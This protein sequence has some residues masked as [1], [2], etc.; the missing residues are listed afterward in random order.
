MKKQILLC[1]LVGFLGIFL[2]IFILGLIQFLLL[3]ILGVSIEKNILT[4]L[5]LMLVVGGM[6]I[7]FCIMN[8]NKYFKSN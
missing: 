5:S 7:A 1:T 8:D 2:P 4:P 6:F 3:F